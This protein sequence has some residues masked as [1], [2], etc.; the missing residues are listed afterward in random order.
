MN[1]KGA[2]SAE[3]GLEKT[4]VLLCVVFANFASLRFALALGSAVR[5]A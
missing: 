3:L 1:R 4:L 5:V 2:K